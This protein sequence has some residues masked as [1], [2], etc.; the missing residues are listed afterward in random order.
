[1]DEDPA[2][3]ASKLVFKKPSKKPVRD[4]T[5]GDKT[6]KPTFVGSKQVLP[7]HVVGAPAAKPVS[8]KP[9]L[10]KQQTSKPGRELKLSH[11][12]DEEEED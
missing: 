6:E 9:V 1:M 8:K 12:D 4:E 10:S 3:L 5:S 2:D 11:L 7:E